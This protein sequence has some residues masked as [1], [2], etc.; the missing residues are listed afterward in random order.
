M[1]PNCH[2]QQLDV[3]RLM[4]SWHQWVT[5]QPYFMD[6]WNV[7]M[8]DDFQLENIVLGNPQNSGDGSLQH[9]QLKRVISYP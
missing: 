2:R 8:F 6:E 9:V 7:F 3:R 1:R 4:M 5:Y